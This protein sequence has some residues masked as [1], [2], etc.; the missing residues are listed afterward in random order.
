MA[1]D[2]SSTAASAFYF[3]R[4]FLKWEYYCIKIL[5]LIYL[6]YLLIQDLLSTLAMFTK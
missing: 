5:H 4:C 1:E 6:L 3:P 2:S